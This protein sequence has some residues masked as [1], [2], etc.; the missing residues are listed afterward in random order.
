MASQLPHVHARRHLHDYRA[1]DRSS[2]QRRPRD[3]RRE[4]R[5][6]QAQAEAEEAPDKTGS[7]K[8]TMIARRLVLIAIA[9]MLSAPAI[10][11]AQSLVYTA[12][13]PTAGTLYRDGQTG[14][15][16][17]GGEWLSRPDPSNVGT[18]Q[19]W[20]AGSSTAGWSPVT[21]PNSYNA[22]DF[23]STS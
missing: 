13:P 2:R 16:L 11:H 14:R 8:A 15:Y 23:S 17:L 22:G 5:E 20:Y 9:I 10:A 19:Q 21:V 3:A 1:G 4:D 18:A 12:T 7:R 6:A